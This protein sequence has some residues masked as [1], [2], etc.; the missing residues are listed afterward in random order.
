MRTNERSGTTE[1]LKTK[2]RAAFE[3]LTDD[4]KH[5]VDMSA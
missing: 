3:I 4:D 5:G 1:V 2:S